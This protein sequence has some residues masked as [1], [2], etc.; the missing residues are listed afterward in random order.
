MKKSRSHVLMAVLVVCASSLA[1]AG[2][3]KG[4]ITAQGARDNGDAVIYI[5]N[6]LTLGTFIYRGNAS[7]GPEASPQSNTFTEVGGDYNLFYGRWNLFGGLGIRH[8]EQPFVGTVGQS[9][10]TTTWFSE[11]DYVVYPWLLPGVRLESWNSHSFDPG[12]DGLMA[13]TDT[14]IVPGIVALVRPNLKLTLRTS[15]A[16]LGS[17]NDSKYQIGQVMLGMAL[18]I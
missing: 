4:K 6:S 17:T 10:N 1:L 8:D 2:G 9:A 11:L 14:Q 3:I 5:D 7:I 15:I 12:G 16:K 13:Y 18:G